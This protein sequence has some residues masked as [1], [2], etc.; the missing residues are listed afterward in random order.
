SIYTVYILINAAGEGDDGGKSKIAIGQ[1]RRATNNVSKIILEAYCIGDDDY[2]T[3][4]EGFG[5]AADLLQDNNIDVSFGVLGLPAG[6]IESLEASTG[7]VVMLG[8]SDEAIEN[9]ESTS[10]YNSY[11]I[12]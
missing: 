5:D 9:I 11:T 10:D 1:E 3:Y 8:I 6:N 7:D 12:P 2:Q 4:E